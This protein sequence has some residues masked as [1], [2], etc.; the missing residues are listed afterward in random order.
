MYQIDRRQSLV[1]RATTNL[2]WDNHA[3]NRRTFTRALAAGALAIAA[4][5]HVW[6]AGSR[7]RLR[8]GHTGITWGFTPADAE[9]A[10]ADVASLGFHAYESFGRVLEAWE[11]KGGLKRLLDA[12]GMPLHSAYCPVNLIDPARRRDEV[13]KLTRWAR[14]IRACGGSVA[15]IGPNPVDRSGY[16]LADHRSHIVQALNDMARAVADVGIAG[17][18]H[19]HTDTC[20]ET[21][22]ETYA[23]MENVDTRY[24]MFGPD[25]GQLQKAG[26]DPVK[27]VRDFLPL[28][29]HVHL[30]DFVGGD[31]YSGYGPLGTGRVD[32]AAVVDALESSSNEPMIMCELD[33]S[34]GQPLAP[35]DAARLNR[36][37]MAALGYSFRS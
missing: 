1:V 20:V 9:Q 8:V 4:P 14:L 32:I 15:V 10:I 7:R 33:P 2:S 19:P 31:H 27:V 28:V 11:E 3:V 35:R 37:A 18:L 29:R 6:P 34:P 12:S 25:V 23:V 5:A 13:E 22:E 24:V 36:T 26:A 17:V 21:R 16:R 30:K